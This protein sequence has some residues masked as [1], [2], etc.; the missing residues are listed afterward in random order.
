M[1][2]KVGVELDELLLDVILVDTI[3]IGPLLTK[4]NYEYRTRRYLCKGFWIVYLE[5]LLGKNL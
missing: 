2:D 4:N 3:L 5:Y 1:R